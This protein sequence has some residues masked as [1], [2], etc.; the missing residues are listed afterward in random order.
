LQ[1]ILIEPIKI[2]IVFSPHGQS[3]MIHE[4]ESPISTTAEGSH[5]PRPYDAISSMLSSA[6]SML[7]TLRISLRAVGGKRRTGIGGAAAPTQ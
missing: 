1:F 3:I 2:N 5:E 7:A 4:T 6:L